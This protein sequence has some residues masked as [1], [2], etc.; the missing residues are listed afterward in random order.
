M[1]LLIFRMILSSELPLKTKEAVIKSN[2]VP[3]TFILFGRLKKGMI[4]I[5]KAMLITIYNSGFS[6]WDKI[7][8]AAL[9][10]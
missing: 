3:I 10:K 7:S 1:Y 4:A 8:K 9:I 2:F 5:G 6:F